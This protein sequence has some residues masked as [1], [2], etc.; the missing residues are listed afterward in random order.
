VP[1]LTSA[2]KLAVV[3][4]ALE[5]AHEEAAMEPCPDCHGT[6]I[7]WRETRQLSGNSVREPYPCRCTGGEWTLPGTEWIGAK[8]GRCGGEPCIKGT[9]FSVSAV[10]S[11]LRVKTPAEMA[12]DW[13]HLPLAA[14]EEIDRLRREGWEPEGGWECE[15]LPEGARG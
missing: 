12:R 7:L 6:Q 8:P 3:L 4:R 13:D 9:R 11:Y 14:F 15:W 2:L 10:L 1:S 5:M